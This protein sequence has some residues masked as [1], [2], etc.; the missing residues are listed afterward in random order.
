M[1]EELFSLFDIE[2]AYR[3]LKSYVYHDNYSH[4]LRAQIAKFESSSEK[5]E[6]GYLKKLDNLHKYLNKNDL[7]IDTRYFQKLFKKITYKVLPKQIKQDIVSNNNLDQGQI[8]TNRYTSEQYNISKVNLFIDAPVELHIIT[9]LWLMKLGYVLENEYC[10]YSNKDNYD[11]YSYAYKLKFDQ[12][13]K[14]K[15]LPKI[16]EGNSLF[17]PYFIQY[18][19]WRDNALKVI[20]DL[21]E[22]HNKDIVLFSLDIKNYFYCINLDFSKLTEEIEQIFSNN[23]LNDYFE[24][25]TVLNNFLEKIHTMYLEQTN[26][27]ICNNG[28]AKYIPIGL[29]SSGVIANWYLKS[30]D[31][32]VIKHSGCEY[33]GRYVDDII[34]VFENKFRC[35]EKYCKRSTTKLNCSNERELTVE[36]IIHQFFIENKQNPIIKP[37]NNKKNSKSE[38]KY[39]KITYPDHY[40]NL[41]IQPDKIKIFLLD[42]DS[43]NAVLKQFEKTIKKHSSEFR[44]LPEEDDIETDFVEN[45]YYMSYTDSI[46]KLRSIE[47]HT[48]D[49]FSTSLYLAKQ[50]ELAKYTTTEREDKQTEKEILYYFN[51]RVG[52]ELHNFWEKAFTYYIMNNSQKSFMALYNQLWEQLERI[53]ILIDE[54]TEVVN[55]NNNKDFLF[56][57]LNTYLKISA[58]MAL[59]LNPKFFEEKNKKYILQCLDSDF[60]SQTNEYIKSFRTSNLIRHRY[61]LF[62]LVNYEEEPINKNKNENNQLNEEHAE[63]KPENFRNLLSKALLNAKENNNK[64]DK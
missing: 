41:I 22:N 26:E 64:D 60:E 38:I 55:F 39:Y 49:N 31:K 4:F 7:S 8:I 2:D 32:E 29:L 52:L 6:C 10:Y 61:I 46:H 30:F 21:L 3:K 16:Q 13:N 47:K 35:K 33:Y 20:E 14:D 40:P 11:E 5:L 9:V 51:G 1:S 28:E 37:E 23:K 44:L 42:K 25:Y 63:E 56:E 54:E 27:F 45:A 59:A 18:Q 57:D 24:K 34:L 62:P 48:Y 36:K 19:R 58:S 15:Q 53:N 50:V 12:S 43:S 17:K